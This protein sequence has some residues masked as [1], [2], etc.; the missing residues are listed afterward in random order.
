MPLPW[1]RGDEA[2]QTL[3][4]VDLLPF[5]GG[6][7]GGRSGD[8]PQEAS[9]PVL[10]AP[11]RDPGEDAENHDM[12]PQF[13]RTRDT[14]GVRGG[15][16]TAAPGPH[17]TPPDLDRTSGEVTPDT[18]RPGSSTPDAGTPDA[19]TPD[20]T[21]TE[22]TTPGAATLEAI[23][24]D[25]DALEPDEVEPATPDDETDDPEDES[26]DLQDPTDTVTL[27]NQ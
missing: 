14:Q 23:T 24:S 12:P 15:S 13:E 6:A 2:D 16:T 4:W 27:N 19:G 5:V 1:N 20:T 21:T 7:V 3:E 11:H 25:T 8:D 10:V 9:K 18:A 26:G 17:E 22:A